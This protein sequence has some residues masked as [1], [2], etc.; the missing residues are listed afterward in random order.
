MEEKTNTI[1][2]NLIIG[3]LKQE[4][5][6][7]EL[8]LFNQ[9][10]TLPRNSELFKEI[11]MLWTNIQH[12]CEAYTPDKKYYW[13]KLSQHI[14]ADKGERSQKV[15]GGRLRISRMYK[16]IVAACVT[17]LI[18]MSFYLGS[19]MHQVNGS[20][21]EYVSLGGKSKVIL[22]DG[23]V[24]WLNAHSSLSYDAR[25]LTDKRVVKL[26]GEAYF[27]VVHKK[28]LPFIVNTD[29]V[30]VKVH[31]TKFDVEAFVGEDL[32]RVSL[33]EGKVSMHTKQEKHLLSPGECGTY[34]KSNGKVD[35]TQSDVDFALSWAQDKL[36]F[37]N[38]PL[39]DVCRFLSKWY[40]VKI[41][42]HPSLSQQ[43][44]YTFT[45]RDE[46]LEEILR[47]MS[48]IHPFAYQFDEDNHLHLTPL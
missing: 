40:R 13:E 38:R 27:D 35:V 7:E 20:S 32:V 34:N 29:G 36:E 47:L 39:R 28:D 5:T 10:I 15:A 12:N 22:P 24:V 4:L 25:F 23:S 33:K 11:S 9:W 21:Q 31:G 2:W 37:N 42:V 26:N 45:L 6:D 18:G 8:E 46:P 19:D 17:L 41:L 30:E 16:Y 1:P 48:K 14:N 3:R 43:Y 44:N